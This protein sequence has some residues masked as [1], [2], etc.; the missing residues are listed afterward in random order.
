MLRKKIYKILSGALLCLVL[1]MA[2]VKADTLYNSVD[3]FVSKTYE[4]FLDRD[5]SDDVGV[6]YWSYLIRNHEK[7]LYDYMI[8]ILSGEEF[9]SREITDESFLEMIYTVLLNRAPSEEEKNYWLGK[10]NE[11]NEQLND[12][13]KA[14]VEICKIMFK[15]AFFNEF[16]DSLKV[17]SDFENLNNF[18]VK[19]LRE[20]YGHDKIEYIN[21]FYKGFSE[22]EKELHDQYVQVENKEQFLEY[23]YGILPIFIKD[24]IDNKYEELK[25]VSGDSVE[26]LVHSFDYEI[27]F[28]YDRDKAVYISTF[29]QMNEGENLNFVTFGLSVT[30]RGL[31][32]VINKA[33]IILGNESIDLE[34][35]YSDQSKY[36][37]KGISVHEFEFKINSIDDLKLLD[38]MLSSDLSKLRFTFDDSQTYIYNLYEKDRVRNTLRFMYSVY[39]QIIASYLFE[40]KD[41]FDTVVVKSLE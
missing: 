1:N 3:D 34:V 19:E 20:D 32:K 16:A 10:L 40:T 2:V 8:S 24:N 7:S 33:E 31:G 14:R 15:E 17:T 35:K 4:I 37:S 26:R 12:I 13:K 29:L 9:L 18:G 11:Q 41:V 22:L 23:I 36:D 30:S 27:A 39:A 6:E 38:K 5:V 21:S 28:P 25:N